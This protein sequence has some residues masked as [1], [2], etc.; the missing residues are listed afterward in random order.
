M[1]YIAVDPQGRF[2]EILGYAPDPVKAEGQEATGEAAVEDRS[3]PS[4]PPVS[5]SGATGIQ[6]RTAQDS[7]SRGGGSRRSTLPSSRK[8]RQHGGG[9]PDDNGSSDNDGYGER[10]QSR[11]GGPPNP[12]GRYEPR[13]TRRGGFSYWPAESSRKLIRPRKLRAHEETVEDMT[14]TL[15]SIMERALSTAI[16]L[17]NTH[18]YNLIAKNIGADKARPV[19]G[20][21]T[22]ALLEEEI[23]QLQFKMR[24]GS[25]FSAYAKQ[26]AA[27]AVSMPV[28]LLMGVHNILMQA[29][30]FACSFSDNAVRAWEANAIHITREN[31]EL[32]KAVNH[33]GDSISVYEA[34]DMLTGLQSTLEKKVEEA[35][36][37][38]A[39]RQE[40]ALLMMRAGDG[41]KAPKQTSLKTPTRRRAPS[42]R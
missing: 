18:D 9:D 22:R 39:K 38:A 23:Q 42:R 12:F 6:S 2:K 14:K 17:A 19:S 13:F 5:R 41:R 32:E 28:S 26:T 10:S 3:S 27:E 30:R 7:V 36:T 24:G 25:L 37:K 15:G 40:T 33:R 1:V 4:R 8:R 21:V 34:T 35:L 29:A 11:A 20:A 31:E 16:L